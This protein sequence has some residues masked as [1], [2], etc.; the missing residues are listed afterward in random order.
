M[1]ARRS[2]TAKGM[3]MDESLTDEE[4][5]ALKAR[6][7]ERLRS[8]AAELERRHQG[9]GYKERGESF[10][11]IPEERISF[12]EDLRDLQRAGEDIP[13]WMIRPPRTIPMRAAKTAPVEDVIDG[14]G[15]LAEIK[16][17]L[18]EVDPKPE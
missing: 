13:D 4:R 14:T 10:M 8:Q 1:M 2:A 5:A 17:V 6:A 7:I 18:A 3:L 12:N 11:T 9:H 15:L 16:R